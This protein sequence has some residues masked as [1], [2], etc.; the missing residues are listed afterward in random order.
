MN[1]HLNG[2]KYSLFTISLAEVAEVMSDRVE[3]LNGE[4]KHDWF[5]INV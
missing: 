3:D 1:A 2:P 4:V 5:Q